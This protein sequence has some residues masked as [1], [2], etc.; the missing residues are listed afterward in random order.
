[1]GLSASEI[2]RGQ[3]RMPMGYSSPATWSPADLQCPMGL[4]LQWGF[5]LAT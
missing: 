1:M 5:M 3:V 2:F 4:D